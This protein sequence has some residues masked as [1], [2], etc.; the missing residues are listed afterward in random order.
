MRMLVLASSLA[1]LLATTDQARAADQRF[2]TGAPLPAWSWSGCA[3]GPAGPGCPGHHTETGRE[4]PSLTQIIDA[5]L[6][7]IGR[8]HPGFMIV[9]HLEVVASQRDL[10]S[11][12]RTRAGVLANDQLLIFGTAGLAFGRP[13]SDIPAF[14]RNPGPGQPVLAGATLT[15]SDAQRLGGVVG[16]GVEWAFADRWRVRGEYLYT[17]TGLRADS[18]TSLAGTP[19]YAWGTGAPQREHVVRGGIN[20]QLDPLPVTA[21]GRS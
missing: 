15:A 9:P 16:G 3:G 6:A 8:A 7:D 12:Y 2:K 1:A 14:G 10:S 13:G 18:S 5:A 21:G 17:H 4:W 20:Y 11:T 19:G